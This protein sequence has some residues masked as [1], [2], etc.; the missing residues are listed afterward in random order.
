MIEIASPASIG[1]TS[2]ARRSYDGR[3]FANG[4]IGRTAAEAADK[5]WLLAI[6]FKTFINAM[7][8]IP[9]QIVKQARRIVYRVLAYNPYQPI[10]F[11]LV[12]VLR[13]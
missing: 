4:L 13:C 3:E 10:F 7:I 8:A 9:C 6:E 1:I 2:G 11:R 12:S 5:A